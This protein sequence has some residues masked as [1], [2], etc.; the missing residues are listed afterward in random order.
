MPETNDDGQFLRLATDMHRLLE[1]ARK[2]GLYVVEDGAQAHGTWYKGKRCG[3]MGTSG[4]SVST[5][6]RTWAPTEAGDCH[7][8]RSRPG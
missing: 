6:E 2:H 8:E 1:I 3:S 7:D 5:L 4:V